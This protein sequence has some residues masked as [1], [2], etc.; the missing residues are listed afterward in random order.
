MV[1][2]SFQFN[3]METQ[4]FP[5]ANSP[6]PF[7]YTG[8]AVQNCS[9]CQT[10]AKGALIRSRTIKQNSCNISIWFVSDL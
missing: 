3:G 10:Q 5:S 1:I 2:H 4:G 8:P 7:R 9:S 6:A